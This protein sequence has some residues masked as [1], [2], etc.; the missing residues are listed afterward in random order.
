MKNYV[1][2]I[3]G[4]GTK[5]IAV[6]ADFH[7]HLIARRIGLASNFQVLSRVQFRSVIMSLIDELL[8]RSGVQRNQV[9]ETFLGIAGIGRDRDKAAARSIIEDSDIGMKVDVDH[10][11]VGALAGAFTG[12]IGI[13]LIAGTGSICFGRTPEGKLIR[14]GGWGY[15]LGD[16]GSGYYI[17]QQGIIAA[18]KHRDG[19]GEDTRLRMLF[20]KHFQIDSIDEVIPIIYQK[21]FTRTDMAALAPLVFEAAAKEDKMAMEIITR[22]GRELGRMVNAVVARMRLQNEPVRLALEG[23][24]F[25]KKKLLIPAIEEEIRN[26]HKKFEIVSPVFEPSVGCVILA[27]EGLGVKM[28]EGTIE[29]MKRTYKSFLKGLTY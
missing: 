29:N 5:T 17:A 21:K 28:N 26:F 19:R 14:S 6:L 23:S 9:S 25:K 8:E 10:D 24:V 15:L 22:A 1:I 2:G 13:I 18:L 20:E 11:A 27:L 4:G 16:E 12:K 7:G 3:D